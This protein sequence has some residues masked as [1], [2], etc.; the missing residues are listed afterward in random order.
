[1][2]GTSTLGEK[3]PVAYEGLPTQSLPPDVIQAV[4][5]ALPTSDPLDRAVCMGR[6]D[7]RGSDCGLESVVCLDDEE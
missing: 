7:L 4:Q 1:M 5:E 3:K 2:D 6:F